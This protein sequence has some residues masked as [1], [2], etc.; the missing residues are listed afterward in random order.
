MS[1]KGV[2]YRELLR[3]CLKD[4]WTID[5]RGRHGLILTKTIGGR[6][7]RVTIADKNKVTPQNVLSQILGPKQTGYGREGLIRLLQKK[8]PKE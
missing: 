8:S 7:R 2:T 6:I 5:R 3:L 4:G 1:M